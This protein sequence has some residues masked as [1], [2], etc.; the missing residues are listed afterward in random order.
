VPGWQGGN[1]RPDLVDTT[2]FSTV[3]Q[4]YEI[5]SVYSEPAAV[6]KV[7]LYVAILNKFDK[8]R[9]WIPGLTYLPPPII[10]VDGSTVAF[11]SR[12][13][14]GVISYCLINQTE[15]LLAVQAGIASL[16]LDLAT[17]SLEVAYAF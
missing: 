9:T 1:L 16:A 2:T 3:G 6:A 12:P 10:P 4:V 15:L 11:I 7:A 14:P 8:Q 17:A 13:Y 5:K